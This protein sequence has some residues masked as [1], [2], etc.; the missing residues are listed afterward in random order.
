MRNFKIIFNSLKSL[1]FKKL[2]KLLKLTLPHPLFSTMGLIAT[3]R[4]FSLAQKHFPKSHSNNGVGN[5]FRHS[6]WTCLIMMYCSKVS[7]P[8]KALDFC[9]KITDLHEELFPNEPLETKMDLHNNKIG[10]DYFMEL[11]PGI[12]RR[13]SP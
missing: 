6:L 3:L 5:A 10:M 2:L 11:L 12:H 1:S 4:S 7:S 9:K 13:L 8:Q